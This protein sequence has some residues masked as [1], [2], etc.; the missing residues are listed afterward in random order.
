MKNG[1]GIVL[2]GHGSTLK[3]ANE[4]VFDLSNFLYRAT[5]LRIQPAFLQ[6][7]NPN[8]EEAATLLINDGCQ[9]LVF[10]PY[11]LYKGQH[12]VS[13]LPEIIASLAKKWP[14]VD[15]QLT[16]PVGEDE[17]LAHIL[18]DKILAQ[19]GALTGRQIEELSL[20]LVEGMALLPKNPLERQVAARVVHATGDLLLANQLVFASNFFS[21]ALNYL[22]QPNPVIVTD[23]Q[24]VAVGINAKL[25][26]ASSQIVCYLD[27]IGN[28]TGP[29]RKTRCQLAVQKAVLDYPQAAIV[30][31]NAPTALAEVLQLVKDGHIE[32]PFIVGVPV[33]FVGAQ[34]VKEKLRQTDIAYVTLPG[35]R[36]GSPVAAAIINAVLKLA[37]NVSKNA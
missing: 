37:A 3:A 13:D 7:V 1:L 28:K 6:L 4:T 20:S 30:I 24:M 2:V 21:Q 11:F 9:K 33:G 26:P 19:A 29:S 15:F 18:V 10:I 5:G 35:T 8:I 27:K 22:Q 23:V 16:E 31:G 14:L 36:G 34:Q 17:R 32:P 12:V 25:L